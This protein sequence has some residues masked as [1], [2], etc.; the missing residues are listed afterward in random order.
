[1]AF[2]ERIGCCKKSSNNVYVFLNKRQGN[3]KT[4]DATEKLD[5]PT[6][7]AQRSKGW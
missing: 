4:L 7:S 1:M 3:A 2:K 6:V 5:P